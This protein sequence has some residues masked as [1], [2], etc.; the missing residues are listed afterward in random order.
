MMDF[1][2]MAAILA[3]LPPIQVL[4]LEPSFKEPP[5]RPRPGTM[6]D[7]PPKKMRVPHR[8]GRRASHRKRRS[9][10]KK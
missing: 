6:G 1:D 9:K 2:R 7:R 3:A 4:Y 5:P 8:L 10:R